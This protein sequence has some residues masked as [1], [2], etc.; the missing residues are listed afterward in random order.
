MS[1][2]LIQSL[3][4][5]C[6]LSVN[7]LVHHGDASNDGANLAETVLTPSNV[8]A[9]DFGKQFTT[10]L[11][12]QVYAQPLYVQNV[13]ITRGSSPG[14][15]SVVFAATMH[16][17]L[18]AVN[19]NT[20]AILWQDNF[21]D[22]AN[23]TKLTASSGVN[24]VP[25]TA[26]EISGVGPELGILATPTIDLGAGEL[27]LNAATQE[28]RGADTHY[29][30]RLW[31]VRLSDG[32]VAASAVIG[33]TIFNGTNFKSFTGY[34]YVAGPI[35][36]GTGNNKPSGAAPTYP[37]TDGW[38]AAPGG[39]SG[40]VIAFNPI[41]QMQRTAVTLVNGNV[42]LG[43][44]SHGDV[45]PYYGWLLGYKE[46]NLQLAAAFVTAPT[47]E[48]ISGI[49]FPSQ[50]GIWMSGSAIATD[51]TYLY[52]STGNGAFN[53]AA[54]NFDAQGFPLDHDYGDSVL[55]L[56][57]D[58]TS[59]STNQNGNGWG[60]KV[61]DYFT[62]SNEA[63]LNSLDMDLGSG[64][65]TLL[66]N[67]LKDKAGNPM[68]VVGGK[69]SRVYLLD[70]NKLGKFNFNYPTNS[71]PDPRNYDRVLG[72]YPNNGFETAGHEI[73][74]SATYFNGQF[75]IGIRSNPALTFSISKFPSGTIPPGTSPSPTPLQ[76]TTT[77]FGYPG[78]TFT[79][80]AN[81]STNGILWATT[82]DKAPTDGL[83][84]YS[85]TNFTSPIYSSN[86]VFSRDNL[87]G[88]VSQSFGT[89]F[90]VPT[91]ANGMVYVTTAS[92]STGR[93]GTLVGYGLLSTYL[94]SNAAFF[95]AP[96]GLGAAAISTSDTRLTWTSHSSLAT[97]F[98]IDRSTNGSTWTTLAYASNN[99]RTYDDTTASSHTSYF[100]RVVAISGASSTP[101][102]SVRRAAT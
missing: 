27:F 15:R 95:S 93:L 102:K 12:G 46:S 51:G 43:F 33:D 72:E 25:S 37:D 71:T 65:V 83:F 13:K 84:A 47:Y 94:K 62:P 22:I 60:L 80:S 70:R 52:L 14:V 2:H 100:Y 97:E 74:S 75:Y 4:R 54:S 39:K 1:F 76:R 61:A 44:A 73:Y 77:V 6:L 87:A 98:R 63:S 45:G 101:S 57:V 90:G 16:D 10:N 11:D 20:G 92:G 66:P 69:E 23:P 3:E 29:V 49:R 68:L 35:V 86:T 5:R 19:A 50:A 96:S 42:Y 7:V 81:G 91:V 28:V 67:S 59:S 8:N 31:A 79:L 36:N 85:A 17:S 32:S 82:A 34:R 99:A 30:Q 48:P 64:G 56:A 53:P 38:A 58:G 41:L 26:L 18:Y 88:G 40:Y 55:K 21:L 78:P 89:R 9:K 24:T